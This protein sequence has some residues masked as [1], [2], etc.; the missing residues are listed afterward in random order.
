MTQQA[1]LSRTDGVPKIAQAPH[2]GTR[3]T[4]IYQYQ[5]RMFMNRPVGMIRG[6]Y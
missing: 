3:Y 6:V 5:E 1:F 4:M 2:K